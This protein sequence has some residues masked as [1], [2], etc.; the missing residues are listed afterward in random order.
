[1]HSTKTAGQKLRTL[2]GVASDKAFLIKTIL[3]N[4]R[5]DYLPEESVCEL[6]KIKK[7]LD[8]FWKTTLAEA[9]QVLD[10]RQG[11]LLPRQRLEALTIIIDELCATL[12]SIES[13]LAVDESILEDVK[14]LYSIQKAMDRDLERTR[15]GEEIAW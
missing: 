8:E 1:M 5:N 3:E 10:A 9:D 4:F 13:L 11:E 12:E 2:V 15:H 6:E 14:N 7:K